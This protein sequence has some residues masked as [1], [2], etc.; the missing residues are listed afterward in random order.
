M[1]LSIAKIMKITMIG[2]GSVVFT[3]TVLTDV[4]SFADLR[5]ETTICL[6]DLDEERLNL[7]HGYFKKYKE[8]NPKELENVTFEATTDQ[9]KAITDA[10]YIISAIQAGGLDAYKVDMDIPYKY[11]V[12]QVVGD[13]LG[14]GGVFRF[15]R[16]VKAFDP[17][18]KDIE[19]VGEHGENGSSPLFLNYTNP[20]CMNTWYCNEIL[21]DSTVG[22]CHGVQGTANLLKVWVGAT[23]PGEFD[24]FCAGINHMAWFLKLWYRDYIEDPDLK[25]PWM[26]AYPIL[27]EHLEEEPRMIGGEK[28][29]VDM[30]KATGYFMTESPGHLAEYLPYYLKRKDLIEKYRDPNDIGFGSLDQANY[31]NNNVKRLET[32]NVWRMELPASD[33][34]QDS[35]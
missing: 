14:P 10:R 6:E 29:R 28:V 31:Y 12:H 11:G 23:M 27:R 18:L 5:K 2:A 33:R 3:K 19:E 34:R 26:D 16:T 17:I 20:M 22:L 15:L 13:S 1:A 25:A 21:P 7:I 8:D 9:R 35:C 32:Y 24:Y 4:L 30:F